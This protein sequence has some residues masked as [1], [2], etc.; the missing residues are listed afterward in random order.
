M[1][2]DTSAGQARGVEMA[3]SVDIPVNSG[4]EAGIAQG[5]NNFATTF[6]QAQARAQ[7]MDIQ[8]QQF[9]SQRQLQQLQM[10]KLQQEIGPT[11]LDLGKVQLAAGLADSNPEKYDT[12]HQQ[13]LK[14]AI[15]N[16]QTPAQLQYAQAVASNALG[17]QKTKDLFDSFG[18]AQPAQA[19]VPSQSQGYTN[20]GTISM[21]KAER[22]MAE[23]LIAARTSANLNGARIAGQMSIEQMKAAMQAAGYNVELTKARE[24]NQT[25]VDVARIK[26]QGKSRDKIQEQ[27]AQGLIKQY[28]DAQAVMQK[29]PSGF[30]L[31]SPA[32][33]QARIQA[34]QAAMQSAAAALKRQFNYD[35]AAQ[36]AAV[37]PALPGKR[38]PAPAPNTAPAV[39]IKAIKSQV[40]AD[41]KFS[42]MAP[43]TSFKVNGVKFIKKP[44]GTAEP[45]QE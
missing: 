43:G 4:T 5:L 9:E 30:S 10:M 14:K 7:Q 37:A 26:S 33:K 15:D 44:D 28:N 23:K 31:E 8:R 6:Q 45:Q 29:A 18:V 35:I 41:P 32:D 3:S 40:E 16:I 21:N 27:V 12:L 25:E 11:Q 13:Y 2:P 1:R 38:M 39:D 22:E 24:H 34:A 17:N 20:P 19:P 36:P 42:G